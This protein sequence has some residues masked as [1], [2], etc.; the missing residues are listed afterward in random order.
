MKGTTK[1]IFVAAMLVAMTI[2]TISQTPAKATGNWWNSSWAN[3]KNITITNAYPVNYAHWIQLNST[4]INYSHLQA[5]GEDI[6]FTNGTCADAGTSLN[7][8]IENWNS[9]G[10]SNV[11]VQTNNANEATMAM[12]YNNESVSAMS[13]IETT[14]PLGDEFSSTLNTTKWGGDTSSAMATGGYGYMIGGAGWKLMNSSITIPQPARFR[15]NMQFINYAAGKGTL[16]GFLDYSG[17]P[18][19]EWYTQEGTENRIRTYNTSFNTITTNTDTNMNIYMIT[20]NSSAAAYF[21]N[22]VAMTGSPS[23]AQL[24]T[25]PLPVTFGALGNAAN[26]TKI[27]WVFAAKWVSP[28]P[29]YDYSAE[30]DYTPANNAPTVDSVDVAPAL[31]ITT[32]TLEGNATCSDIDGGDTITAYWNWYQNDTSISNGDAV[33][34][35]GV[36]TN[37]ADISAAITTKTDTYIFGVFCGDGTVNT[38]EV[39]SSTLTIQNSAPVVTSIS[40]VNNHFTSNI[41]PEFVF[42]VTD[43]DGDTPQDCTLDINGTGYG[44]DSSTTL[45]TNTTIAANASLADNIYAWHINCTDGTDSA[46]SAN[47]TITIDTAAPTIAY[48]SNSD[49][50]NT[51]YARNWTFTN[52]TVTDINL[53]TVTFAWNGVNETFGNNYYENKTDLADG[54]YTVRAWANDSAGNINS[55]VVRTIKLDTTAPTVTII[56]PENNGEYSFSSCTDPFPINYTVTDSGKGVNTSS[57][58][59]A[60][61][62]SVYGWLDVAHNSPWGVVD[63]LGEE[64]GMSENDTDPTLIPIAHYALGDCNNFTIAFDRCTFSGGNYTFKIWANDTL[65]N[66]GVDSNKFKLSASV[67]GGSGGGTSDDSGITNET[68]LPVPPAIESSSLAK[69]SLII[70][71]IGIS[72]IAMNAKNMRKKKRGMLDDF[73]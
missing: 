64:F 23:T 11:W 1:F 13:N 8:W 15:A 10:T 36:D 31:P 42:N 2:F 48:A 40:P 24:P 27:N 70:I 6:R 39:N 19:V 67:I 20:W 18:A 50:N 14:F 34:T 53:D 56:S 66:I 47:R 58:M 35:S 57:C 22:D 7:Y 37:L 69:I 3:C 65:N 63:V 17:V 21:I 32:E 49:A 51:W 68:A 52:V 12:Y 62:I 72:W 44:N 41:T 16:T 59:F 61:Y 73:I 25:I 45:S 33:V 5:N 46:V 4:Y 30:A 55:T 60:A 28:E 38:T 26:Q 43:A 29:T 9:T 54:S 71:A